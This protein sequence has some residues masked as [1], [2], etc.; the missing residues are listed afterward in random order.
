MSPDEVG[1]VLDFN[2]P[3][4]YY[5]SLTADDVEDLIDMRDTPPPV[6][7]GQEAQWI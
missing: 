3:V 4:E 1:L 7:D 5:G 2:N 6:I